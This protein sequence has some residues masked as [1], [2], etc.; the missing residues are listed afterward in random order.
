MSHMINLY[1][2]RY[3]YLFLSITDNYK[4]DHLCYFDRIS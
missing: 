2:Q 4:I 3:N 1:T